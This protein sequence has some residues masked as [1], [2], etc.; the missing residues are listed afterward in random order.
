MS[1]IYG[2]SETQYFLFSGMPVFE[3][4]SV[5]AGYPKIREIWLTLGTLITAQVTSLGLGIPA[6]AGTTPVRSRYILPEDLSPSS[7]FTRVVSDWN[8]PPTSPTTF[9][10]RISLPSTAIG[11]MNAVPLRFPRA[12]LIVPNGQTMVLW[13]ITAAAKGNFLTASFVFED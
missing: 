8:V 6:V 13:C 2:V 11:A 1:G 3:I 4:V 9:Q 7:T 5:P 12:G 10:R